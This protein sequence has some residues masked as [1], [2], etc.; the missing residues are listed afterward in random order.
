VFATVH[1]VVTIGKKNA[2]D[3]ATDEDGDAADDADGEE[4]APKGKKGKADKKPEK[5]GAGVV[6]QDAFD[7]VRKQ[8]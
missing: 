6:I 5:R 2:A 3:D 8:L 4:E 7:R 1:V